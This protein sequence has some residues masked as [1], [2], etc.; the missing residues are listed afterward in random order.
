MIY[1]HMNTEDW[2]SKLFMCE[3]IPL[4]G[5][6]LSHM[7]DR[8][9]TVSVNLRIR[10]LRK[11]SIYSYTP[12]VPMCILSTLSALNSI[13]NYYYHTEFRMDIMHIGTQS[14]IRSVT[15]SGYYIFTP[16]GGNKRIIL[17]FKWVIESF[18]WTSRSKRVLKCPY[19]AFSNITFHA[20]CHVAVC[21]HKLKLWSRQCTIN[22]VIVYKKKKRVGSQSPERV[23]WNSNFILLRL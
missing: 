4:D 23:V 22:K 2:R 5:A 13:E 17:C 11:E 18:I 16:V 21:E 19:Y 12:Y 6:M 1:T 20:V 9:L 3:I 7:T 10:S 8:K 15:L 14:L